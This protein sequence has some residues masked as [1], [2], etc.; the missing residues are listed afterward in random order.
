MWVLKMKGQ[1]FYVHHVEADCPWSTKETPDNPATKGSL[2]F[3][4]CSVEID[5]DG[6]A[7][8]KRLQNV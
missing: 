1:T 8:I 4:N 3:K 6:N 2:K 5:D 7:T